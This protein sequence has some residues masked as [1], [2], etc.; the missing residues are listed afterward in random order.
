MEQYGCMGEVWNKTRHR[1]ERTVWGPGRV[2]Q[3]EG[4]DHAAFTFAMLPTTGPP[5]QKKTMGAVRTVVM[6]DYSFRVRK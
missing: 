5:T 6:A 4:P 3:Y 2:Q 1:V